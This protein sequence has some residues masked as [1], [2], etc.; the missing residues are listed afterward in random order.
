MH[1][2]GC[3]Y[4]RDMI[5]SLVLIHL[6]LLYLLNLQWLCS[7]VEMDVQTGYAVGMVFLLVGNLSLSRPWILPL[8][9]PLY[10]ILYALYFYNSHFSTA[11]SLEILVLHLFD[12]IG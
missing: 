5:G 3:S 12:Y 4:L 9:L 6:T 11:P 2:S 1:L 8:L 10:I 7:L